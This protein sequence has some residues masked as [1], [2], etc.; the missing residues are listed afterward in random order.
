MV[1]PPGR[2]V[3]RVRTK[4]YLFCYLGLLPV[5]ALF[6]WLRVTPLASTI[7]LSFHNWNLIRPNKPFIGLQNYMNLF[8]DRLFLMALRNT[9][10]FA[11]ATMIAGMIL[12][13]ALAVALNRPSRLTGLYQTLYFLPVITPMV[14]V[15]VIWKWIYD[16]GYGLLNYILSLFGVRPIGWLMYPNLALMS[17]I[18]MCVWKNLGYNMIMFLVGLKNIPAQYYEAAAIDG[19]SRWQAFWRI[20]LPLLKPILLYVLV[21]STIDGFNIFTPVYVMTTGSQ[22]APGNAVRTLVFNIYEEGFRYFKMGYASSQ[23]VML[24]LIVLVL[25]VVQLRVFRGEDASE[26]TQ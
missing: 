25:T 24:L 2:R 13:L 9:A 22:G 6:V 17:I 12:S 1:R 15:S 3:L 8:S 26:G 10:I 16:P 19:A 14:P 20:T 7:N 5:L 4:Q 23:A 18:I 11:F 21:T